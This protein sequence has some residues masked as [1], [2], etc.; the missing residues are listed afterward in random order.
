VAHRDGQGPSLRAEARLRSDGAFV[1]PLLQAGRWW[2]QVLGD[3]LL[4]EEPLAVDVPRAPDA[5]P[6]VLAVLRDPRDGAVALTVK[7][8]ATGALLPQAT[9]RGRHG[10]GT[11]EGTLGAD[12]V[13]SLRDAGLGR[14]E[15]VIGTDEHVATVVAFELPPQQRSLVRDVLLARSN[16]V[17][18]RTLGARADA[19]DAVL[20][21][22]DLI[23][24]HGAHRVETV[25][26]LRA[27]IESTKVGDRV[28]LEVLR[29]G[30]KLRLT[31]DGGRLGIGAVNA[32]VDSR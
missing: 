26:Q 20:R 2:I 13:L 25:P 5:P 28:Q 31:V 12:A 10:Q 17:E 15:Y 4:S 29:D 18:V 27:A 1:L 7:D 23:L 9:F 3:E 14:Y 19:F 32:R 21:V 6:L 11:F 30:S 22:G 8:A 16:A 24:S